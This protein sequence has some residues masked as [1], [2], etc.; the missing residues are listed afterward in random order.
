MAEATRSSASLARDPQTPGKT[1]SK[2]ANH[3]SWSV[4]AEV[5]SNPRTPAKTLLRLAQDK[6]WRCAPKSP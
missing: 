3:K 4:R 2:L 1:L 6:R 5:A